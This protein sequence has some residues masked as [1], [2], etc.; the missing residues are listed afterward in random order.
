MKRAQ[1]Q[2]KCADNEIKNVML[3]NMATK[4]MLATERFPKANDDW[5]DLPKNSCTWAKW[6]EI[7][8]AADL[9]EK[10]KRRRDTPNLAV[11]PP[12]ATTM[13]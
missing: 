3:V 9:R 11:Q 6:K 12:R 1:E 2:S 7:Y 4:A 8:R 13:A 5:E 10:V